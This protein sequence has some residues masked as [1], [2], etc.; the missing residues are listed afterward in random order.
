MATVSELAS[1]MRAASLRVCCSQFGGRNDYV[2]QAPLG[3]GV[4]VD[5]V[6][7]Q[8][9]L[10]GALAADGAAEGDHGRGAEQTDLHAGRGEGRLV[11][12]DGQ[13]AGGDELAAGGGGDALHLGDHRLWNRLDARHQL[14]ADVEDLRGSR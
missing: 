1:A 14:G 4:R 2:D 7:G 11:R 12:G 9:H 6:A 13:I 5:H 3:G 8:Q 10:Q